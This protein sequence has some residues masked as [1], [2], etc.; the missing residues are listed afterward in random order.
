MSVNS[1]LQNDSF[2]DKKQNRYGYDKGSYSEGEIAILEDWTPKEIL[3]RGLRLLEFIEKRWDLKFPSEDYKISLL[4]LKFLFDERPDVPEI[5]EID[6]SSRDD[7]YN[8]TKGE[9]KVSDHLKKKDLYMVEYYFKIFNALK[10]K[11][12]SLY[13][14]A[15][16]HYIALRCAETS[17]NIAEIH[18]QNSKRNI[19][20]NTKPP[21]S[22]EYD[23][24]EKL[25]DNYLWTLNYRVTLKENENFDQALNVI[26]ESYQIRSSSGLTE[27]EIEDDAKKIQTLRTADMLEVVKGF[28]EKGVIELL[29]SDNRYLR[30]TTEIIKE[31]VG[32][33]GDGSWRGVGNHLI[34]YEIKN[35]VD[36][37]TMTLYIG[38][39][40]DEN[41]NKWVEWARNNSTFKVLKGKFWTPIYRTTLF[42]HDDSDALDAISEFIE[43][44]V[45]MIDVEFKK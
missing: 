38:P 29:H 35:N 16:S 6:Y 39:G 21:V 14:T 24:G 36:D 45:P 15:T 18:I 27:E 43:N 13:E 19:L 17:K 4:G 44:V 7:H 28:A 26:Y 8:G 33:L 31:V 42:R 20:I 5:E 12:P 40:A 3:K 30:F 23:I 22:G 1:S 41:R 25:P 32:Q 37:A 2:K 34:V 11:I 9:I 10:E